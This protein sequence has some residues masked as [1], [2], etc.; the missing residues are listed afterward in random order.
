[1][2]MR[3]TL[4]FTMLVLAGA[5]ALVPLRGVSAAEPPTLAVV[6]TE[7]EL[8]PLADL[9]TA[10]LSHQGVQLVERKQ[11]DAVLQEQALSAAGLTDRATLV[12]VGA[13][14]RADAFVLLSLEKGEKAD[15]LRLRVVE[16]VY[17]VRLV[18]TFEEWDAR[19]VDATAAALGGTLKGAVD[20][21]KLPS[22]QV[23]AVGIIGVRRTIL[24]DEYQ[25]LCRALAGALSARLSVEPRIVV[26][27]REDLDLLMQEK[28]LTSGEQEGFWKS[29]VLIDGLLTPA[30]KG[31]ELK[32][33][34]HGAGGEAEGAVTVP[35]SRE[36]P[37]PRC[38][39][40]R[41]NCCPGS[42]TQPT[43]QPG[44]RR[45]RP[46]STYRQGLLL[47]RTGRGAD[48]L[49]ALLT[50]CALAPRKA[51]YA[52]GAFYVAFDR[53]Y[54]SKGPDT[55]D[56]DLAGLA[57]RAVSLLAVDSGEADANAL[58]ALEGYFSGRLSTRNAE[59]RSINSNTRK[60]WA[61]KLF[62]RLPPGMS[63]EWC[64][65]KALMAVD[66]VSE[67]AHSVEAGLRQNVFP[68][69]E[70]GKY[71][72]VIERLQAALVIKRDVRWRGVRSGQLGDDEETFQR[73]VP[74]LPHPHARRRGSPGPPPGGRSGV[75]HDVQVALCAARRTQ[76]VRLEG[77]R[78]EVDRRRRR[79]VGFP[80]RRTGDCGRG[81]GQA[82]WF[83]FRR[84]AAPGP[85]GQPV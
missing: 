71:A 54:S 70:G 81:P 82:G 68:A 17:G 1:M 41:R 22:G 4:R 9:L 36:D 77:P 61:A 7:E 29:A 34:L 48:A 39:R 31:M 8:A 2:T 79:T 45:P 60:L 3:R 52:A 6:E 25:W 47:D 55:G 35:V 83:P 63:N 14:V 16:T 26:L 65:G 23:V 76:G 30:G 27:E 43:A 19:K 75:V 32:L 13:L 84:M 5:F 12:K 46:S 10:Q 49:P 40:R 80:L 42:R 38:S 62:S 74:H 85:P 69:D 37:Q 28:G 73:Q 64:I 53:A 57:A 21:L 24:G 59:A 33:T 72:Q 11:L 66:R 58:N 20:K 44:T 67:A 78:C 50:A 51:E 18:D 15:L 56:V